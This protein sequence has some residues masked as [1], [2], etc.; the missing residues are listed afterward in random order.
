MFLKDLCKYYASCVAMENSTTIRMS[1]KDSQSF[2]VVPWI[3]D[4]VLKHHGI[5]AFVQ[6]NHEKE[7]D[8]IL[9]YPIL[10]TGNF[11]SP[12]FII[13]IAY[14]EGKGRL[15]K[16]FYFEPEISINKDLIDKYSTNDKTENI[17]EL[18]E[19][20]EELG[21]EQGEATLEN[22]QTITDKL[23][24]IRPDWEWTAE[25]DISNL[26]KDFF[27]FDE[28]NGILNRAIIFAKDSTPY[29]VGLLNELSIM[30]QWNECE[31][32]DSILWKFMN[33][34]FSPDKEIS[35][36][37]VE[38]LP[39]NLEQKE[40]VR[41]ALSADVSLIAGPPGTGKTQ[42]VANIIINTV[43]NGQNVLFTSKNN[44]AVDV[45][46]KRVNDMNKTHPL[47]I[48][49]EKSAKQCVSDYAQT[50]ENIV[51]SQAKGLPYLEEYESICNS[52]E[53][54]IQ[55]KK[56]IVDARNK[57]DKL[58]QS[59]A[60]LR[61]QYS[62]YIAT[63]IV[64]TIDSV[65]EAYNTFKSLRQE[66][67]EGPHSL[68][69]KIFHKR[70]EANYYKESEELINIVNTFVSQFCNNLQLSIGM[71][72][73]ELSDYENIY[74]SL[75]SDL[76]LISEY[77][78]Q[79]KLLQKS[80]SLEQL[81]AALLQEHV[82]IQNQ[83]TKLWNYWLDQH[84]SVFSPENRGELHDY[85]SMLDHDRTDM[86][87]NG[88]KKT[89]PANA[90]TSLSARRR[91]P[92]KQAIYDLLI[93]DEASQCDIA[94]MIPLLMR[95]KRVAVIGDKMQLSHI[96]LLSK[97]TDLSLMEKNNI[98]PS[99]SYRSNSIYDLA[100]IMTTANNITQ[101]RNHHRSFLDI[102][103]FSNEEFYG[104]TLRV[105]TDYQRLDSP[106]NGEPILGMKWMDV[107]GH[108]VRP[109][110]GG[111]Y[112]LAEVEAVIRVL[113]RLTIDLEFHGSIGVTTP[114]H[115]QADMIRK[116]LTSDS[117]LRNRLEVVNNLLVDTVHKF[118]GDEKD[119]IIF[120]PVVSNGTQR[121]SL[122]FLKGT[123]NLFNVAITRARALLV[124]VGDKEYCKHCDVSYLEHFAEYTSGQETHV[125]SSEW[126]KILQ[127]ALSD[128]GIPVTAQYHVDKY[129]LDLALFHNGKML[130]IEVDGAMYHQTWDYELCYKDQIR[131]Q[132]LM[133]QG[134]S[135]M[136]FW[137][138]QVRDQ[139]PW[140]VEQVKNWIKMNDN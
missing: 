63:N 123:G 47:I 119:V 8:L 80:T 104:N 29:T 46:V 95:A 102:I 118:Q 76:T 32:L 50:W 92:L 34:K 111:A 89:L 28:D 130:D 137:V 135:V 37:I 54:K 25:L 74:T 62:K 15:P 93:I 109:E 41:K 56:N 48:R 69:D 96:C 18:R 71:T 85:I 112:N 6:S 124:T 22:L 103:Q 91:L 12:V 59:I 61:G 125:E 107:K 81:D 98:S 1:L 106:N 45:V 13:K 14:S 140:C 5:S 97:Q 132:T 87:S 58:E 11:I 65:K 20:E 128:E 53:S 10:K 19:L 39:M 26:R 127:D 42:V 108:T 117:E 129:Y 136:R 122:L 36:P 120:S 133:Q 35:M 88:L 78:L 131:N 110:S 21:F 100:M 2:I 113:R 101:L 116:A 9:G 79:L 99:W 23:R 31:I 43:M 52:Y 51:S 16:G 84:T 121:Q 72:D 40:A 75:M 33:K 94:S 138:Q 139:L 83:A 115:L 126:E 49:Y 86:Y 73:R 60:P 68:K 17:F 27:S 38:V 24:F 64:D 90:I 7:K 44:N 82:T 55:Q 30:E 3:N 67:V 114:F 66:F 134:W 105:A 70:W 77:N 57:L 4:G